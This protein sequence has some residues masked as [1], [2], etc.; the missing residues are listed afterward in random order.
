MNGGVA[1]R[2]RRRLVLLAVIIVAVAIGA[3][4]ITLVSLFQANLDDRRT[5]LESQLDLL[6]AGALPERHAASLSRVEAGWKVALGE[7]PPDVSLPVQPPAPGQTV[8]LDTPQHLVAL[9]AIDSQAVVVAWFPLADL[10]AP[11]QRAALYAACGLVLLLA[12]GLLLFYRMTAPLLRSIEH[13]EARYRTL[14]ANTAEGVLLVGEQIEECNDRFCELFGCRRGDVV[15]LPWRDFFRR[16]SAADGHDLPEFERRA[17]AVL[18]GGEPFAW[19]YRAADGRL[20]VLDVA[21]RRLDRKDPEKSGRVLV[22]LRDVTAREETARVLRDAEQALRESREKL[23]Q[24]GRSSALVELAAGIAHEV[25]QPLAAIA[26]YARASRRLVVSG[27]PVGD[28]LVRTLDRI[29]EQ[30]QRAGSAIHRIRSLVSDTPVPTSDPACIN[31]LVQEVVELM[32][33]EIS[34]HGARVVVTPGADAPVVADPLQIQQ[35]IVQLLRNALEATDAVPPEDRVVHVMTRRQGDFVEVE[36]EDRGQGVTDE[37]RARMF[38]P[39]YSTKERGMGMGLPISMSIIRS[40]RGELAVDE[41]CERGT[42]IRFRLPAD[43][44]SGD[45]RPQE[46][47]ATA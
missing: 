15:G 16:Y 36:V 28:E 24:A 34:R 17:D 42:R 26:N 12:V 45:R 3:V 41:A 19:K 40:H 47:R 18:A 6:A 25:N 39:F 10:R 2:G 37:D 30:A 46:G 8:W 27:K 29:A 4:G 20:L 31:H 13:S 43:T 1:V 35:V 11:F 23:A 38:E 32:A 5:T 14:F 33:D 7:L 21:L 44:R 22:S 9:Q